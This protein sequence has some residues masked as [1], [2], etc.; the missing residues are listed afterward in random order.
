MWSLSPSLAWPANSSQ[1][2]ARGRA[3]EAPVA[4]ST[5]HTTSKHRTIGF[6]LALSVF[7]QSQFIGFAAPV[8]E[9]VAPLP[10]PGLTPLEH[11]ATTQREPT[12]FTI[13][14][15]SSAGTYFAVGEAI[16]AVISHPE[17]SERCTEEAKCGPEGMLAIAQTSD[18]SITNI[19]AVNEGRVASGLAQADLADAAFKG[20]APF[21]TS[22]PLTNFRAIGYLYP[23]TLHVVAANRAEVSTVADLHERRVSIDRPGSG[24]QSVALKV[25]E[26]AG[27]SEQ[28]F[29]AVET[30]TLEAIDM[31]LADEIDALF[32]VGGAP[33]PVLSELLSGGDFSLVGLES[34]QIESLHS[35]TPFFKEA[36]I[37]ADAYETPSAVESINVGALWL[38]NANISRDRIYAITRALWHEDNRETLIA[39]HDQDQFMTLLSV[40]T[41]LPIP[42]HPGAESYY[43]DIGLIDDALDETDGAQTEAALSPEATTN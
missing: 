37:S 35:L 8:S 22:E 23:E 36:V 26:S 15:G 32:F 13:A 27:L 3:A 25:L 6:W 4:D 9:P 16:A 12:F 17:G 14:T 7:A 20:E 28:D 10:K 40:L 42:L 39:G 29:V 2:V 30:S 33:V 41:D 21:H 24:T 31:I 34:E 5:G 11:P 38:V 19:S 1:D 43:V 18:G